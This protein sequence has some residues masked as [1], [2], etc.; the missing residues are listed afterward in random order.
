MS[1]H[2]KS[3]HSC[4]VTSINSSI[5]QTLDELAFE[6]GIWYAAQTG[7]LP[8]VIKLFNQG[9]GLNEIDTAGYTALHYA[10]RNGY[11]DVCKFLLANNVHV[12]AK[13]RAGG[14]TALHRACSSGKYLRL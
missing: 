1:D 7:D 13:T 12:N 10:A 5:Y 14:A 11:L 4:K 9:Q 3:D 8:R 6:R 2:C